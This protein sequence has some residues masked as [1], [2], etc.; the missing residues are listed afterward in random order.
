MHRAPPA[1]DS[2]FEVLGTARSDLRDREPAMLKKAPNAFCIS[3]DSH[4]KAA[5]NMPQIS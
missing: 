1:G 2:L 3:F 5:R 4:A